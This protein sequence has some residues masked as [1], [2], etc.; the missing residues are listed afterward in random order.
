MDEREY[1]TLVEALAAVPDP[2]HQRG[3]RYP[4]A[5]L[6]VLV[7]AALVSGQRH[8]RGIGP[9][10]H[11]HAGQWRALLGWPGTRL[12]SEAT[13]RRAVRCL[14]VERLE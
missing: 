14:D 1:S 3:R 12:P 11:E 9:W 4:W 10:V 5:L 7:A 13:L 6:L 2:R 8:G